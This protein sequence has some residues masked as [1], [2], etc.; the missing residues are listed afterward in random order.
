[1]APLGSWPHWELVLETYQFTVS[2]GADL[3]FNTFR[4]QLG[5][6]MPQPEVTPI[7]SMDFG[8]PNTITKRP[9]VAITP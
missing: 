3:I 2:R 6:H 4:A 5:L 1:M 8:L 9:S 7:K